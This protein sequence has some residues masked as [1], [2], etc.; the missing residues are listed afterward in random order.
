MTQLLHKKYKK[1]QFMKY[2]CVL[3]QSKKVGMSI[4]TKL[5][6]S[7]HDKKYLFKNILNR[8]CT[9]YLG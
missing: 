6:Y 3:E 7:A 1:N 9:V 2:F 8:Q 4:L 5:K